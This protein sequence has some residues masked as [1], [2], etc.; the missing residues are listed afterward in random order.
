MAF[1]GLHVTFGY[2]GGHGSRSKGT[3][4]YGKMTSS[5]LP[6]SGTASVAVAPAILD[7]R[8]PMAS[9]YAVA[10]SWL[11]V[12][13]APADPNV[14]ASTRRFIPATT[15]IDF[16]CDAGDKIRWVAA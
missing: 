11:T 8:D 2:S 16:I 13:P 4:I 7:D 3:P 15:L 12:G 10:D 9:V 5:E 1:S 14:A 6:A